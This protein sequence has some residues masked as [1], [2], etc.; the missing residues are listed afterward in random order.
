MNS[1]KN[2]P[3]EYMIDKK[4]PLSKYPHISLATF[5]SMVEPNILFTV[6]ASYIKYNKD[7]TF[8]ISLPSNA[9]I[10]CFDID[11]L[12]YY[13]IKDIG[14]CSAHIDFKILESHFN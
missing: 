9:M 4:R 13:G 2:I 3:I 7:N 1:I 8:N 5:R 11:K 14:K 12:I 10:R 6:G